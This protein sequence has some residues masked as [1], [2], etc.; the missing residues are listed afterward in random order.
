MS[1]PRYGWWGYVKSMIR[2]Y[3][4][5]QAEL[6]DLHHVSMTAHYS[7]MPSGSRG[8]ALE[9]VAIRDIAPTDRREYDAVRRAIAMTE[10]YPTGKERLHLID[11]VFWENSYSLQGAA[12][13]VPCSIA[14]AKRWHGDFIISVAKNF[15]LLEN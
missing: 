8:R 12:I 6:N 11:L 13:R 1:K 15:G 14:T 4:A 7:G 3:P 9:A 5:L 10:Q 2:R